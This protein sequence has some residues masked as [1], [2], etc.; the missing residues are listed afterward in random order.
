MD[1]TTALRR[2][3]ELDEDAAAEPGQVARDQLTVIID[4]C[5]ARVL[6]NARTGRGRSPRE[7]GFTATAAELARWSALQ[8]G[9]AGA[10]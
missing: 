8:R 10:L 4:E 5:M 6:R 2:F 1:D 7:L 9:Q 3:R